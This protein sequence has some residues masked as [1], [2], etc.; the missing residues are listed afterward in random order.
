MRSSLESV[1]GRCGTSGIEIRGALP[2]RDFGVESL[3]SLWISRIKTHLKARYFCDENQSV[4]YAADLKPICRLHE[5]KKGRHSTVGRPKGSRDKNQRIR[6]FR[7]IRSLSGDMI[8][9]VGI[10]QQQKLRQASVGEELHEIIDSWW[11]GTLN[12]TMEID[13]FRFD[14]PHW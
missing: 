13:P 9:P 5:I 2:P 4:F 11:P 8:Q 10:H 12:C 7:S 1:R 3:R 14:W 6:R